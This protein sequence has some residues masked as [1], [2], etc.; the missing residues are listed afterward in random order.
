ML[1]FFSFFSFLFSFFELYFYL[2]FI[3]FYIFVL[4]DVKNVFF[5]FFGGASGVSHDDPESPNVH[6]GGTHPASQTPPKFHEKKTPERAQ[7]VKFLAGRAKFWA[8]P[9]GPPPFG[10]SGFFVAVFAAVCA[11]SVTVFDAFVGALAD[12]V[13]ATAFALLLL[14]RRPLKNPPLPCDL[15]KCLLLFACYWLCCFCCWCCCRC[16]FRCSLCCVC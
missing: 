12:F 14:G 1:F 5:L 3:V 15:P 16:C 4:F 9:S 6:F 10:P 11:T 2:I 7:R 8:H 13:V